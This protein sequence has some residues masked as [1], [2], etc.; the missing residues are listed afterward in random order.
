MFDED[1]HGAIVVH[2]CSSNIILPRGT[3]QNSQLEYQRFKTAMDSCLTFSH[4]IFFFARVPNNYNGKGSQKY[5][6]KG[7]Q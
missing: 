7:S 6:G 2:T 3:F 1:E 5:Y 4:S